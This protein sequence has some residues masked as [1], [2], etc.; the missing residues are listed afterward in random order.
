MS[1]CLFKKTISE[2]IPCYI[3]KQNLLYLTLFF[4]GLSS[5]WH[6]PVDTRNN[7]KT[8]DLTSTV[9][10]PQ[11][12]EVS[13]LTLSNKMKL[14]LNH[15]LMVFFGPLEQ[16]KLI[17]RWSVNIIIIR[18]IKQIINEMPIVKGYIEWKLA[19]KCKYIC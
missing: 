8:Q 12:E 4:S 17:E 2:G 18:L 1:L 5:Y 9:T 7:K 10:S 19:I 13:K 11:L 16:K 14:T 15:L 3:V 6:K